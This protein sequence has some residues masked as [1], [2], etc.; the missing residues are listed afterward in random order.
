MHQECIHVYDGACGVQVLSHVSARIA[1]MHAAGL[2]HCNV[3]PA[4]VLWLPGENRWGVVDFG[5]AARAG[6]RTPLDFSL[7]YAA[8][9]A[10]AALQ[11]Q[12]HDVEAA[13]ALDV[14][15][16][17][18]LGIELFTGAPAFDI[19]GTGTG[20]VRLSVGHYPELLRQ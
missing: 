1:D 10:A 17:G 3:K 9:E 19:L 2:V 11:L 16:V 20:R 4:N 15:A 6:G 13:P 5:R 7:A 8:P 18:V 12:E 14:W